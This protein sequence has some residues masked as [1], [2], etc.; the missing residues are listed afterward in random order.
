MFELNTLLFITLGA[1]RVGALLLA[2]PIFGPTQFPSGL[3]F[4]LAIALSS[5]MAPLQ[6]ELTAQIL[7]SNYLILLTIV[8]EVL[9]GLVMGFSLRFLFLLLSMSLEFAG[10]QMGFA[11]ASMLDP[12]NNTNIS[13]LSQLG[14]VTTVLLF[15]ATNMHHHVFIALYK[16]FTLL[17]VGPFDLNMGR[18][19]ENLVYFFRTVF[20]SAIRL[21][22]PIMMAMLTIHFVLAIISR[23]APQMNLFF[24]VAFIV[25]ILI[26]FLLVA[27]IMPRYFPAIQ[28]VEEML[29]GRGLGIL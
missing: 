27:L 26:G 23:A 17:P 22:L 12:L 14:V 5:L 10:M 3:R 11:I 7:S 15:F 8:R 1:F 19:I 9:I 18:M 28:Q 20:E 4:V 16:S 2:M 13:V 29:I 24:N 25:N 21:A 6:P